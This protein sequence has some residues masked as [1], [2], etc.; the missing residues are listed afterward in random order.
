MSSEMLPGPG[1]AVLLVE[2]IESFRRRVIKDC[3]N[4]LNNGWP[5]MLL[6]LHGQVSGKVCPWCSLHLLLT[7]ALGERKELCLV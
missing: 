4:I 2:K 7:T 3:S 1:S 6:L 5:G